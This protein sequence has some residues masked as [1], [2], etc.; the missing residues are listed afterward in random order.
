[1]QPFDP[2]NEEVK[3]ARRLRELD[4]QIDTRKIAKQT[5]TESAAPEKLKT[6][7]RVLCLTQTKAAAALGVSAVT[8]KA[9][10]SG[11][12]TPTEKHMDKI[13]WFK[14]QAR[15]QQE[16]EENALAD[17]TQPTAKMVTLAR[18]HLGLEPG[19]FAT[20]LGASLA[21]VADWELGKTVMP[22][23]TFKTVR[24]ALIEKIRDR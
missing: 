21:D 19:A 12:I 9:W 16:R 17:Q 13:T 10:E 14:S 22:G 6:A 5:R 4:Y 24:Q 2:N 20:L 15:A 3:R 11:S 23:E 7:R 1:M 18:R 8:Y